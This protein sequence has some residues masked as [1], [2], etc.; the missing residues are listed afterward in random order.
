VPVGDLDLLTV[1]NDVTRQNYINYPV[2]VSILSPT[3][4]YTIAIILDT[5]YLKPSTIFKNIQHPG[6]PHHDMAYS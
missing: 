5:V 2:Y 1:R 6:A 3:L 4:D